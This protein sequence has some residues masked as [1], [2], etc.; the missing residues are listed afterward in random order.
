MSQADLMWYFTFGLEVGTCLGRNKRCGFIVEDV[1][2]SQSR[3]SVSLV[4][5][6]TAVVAQS[7]PVKATQT[8]RA[9]AELTQGQLLHTIS[10]L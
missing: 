3:V 8:S 10:Q 7:L 4:Q 5:D 2:Q 9:V 1:C 6:G